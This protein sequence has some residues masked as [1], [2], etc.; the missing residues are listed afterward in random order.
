M[1][2]PINLNDAL[3]AAAVMVAAVALSD[4]RPAAHYQEPPA[5]SYSITNEVVAVGSSTETMAVAHVT[6][7]FFSLSDVRPMLGRFFAEPD[8]AAGKSGAA[9]AVLTHEYWTRKFRGDPS[10]I[11]QKI[12]VGGQNVFIVGVAPADFRFV[13]TA[14]LWVPVSPNQPAVR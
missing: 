9:V 12:Q 11:G 5:S 2:R 6:P 1:A 14:G 13:P 4:C 7:D 10:T 8:Y 3:C